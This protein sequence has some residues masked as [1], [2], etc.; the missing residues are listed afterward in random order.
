LE[1]CVPPVD[2][3]RADLERVRSELNEARATRM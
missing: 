3:H 1:Q 2:R